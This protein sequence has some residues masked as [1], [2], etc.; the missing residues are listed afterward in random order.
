MVFA[1]Y[2]YRCLIKY[3]KL[4][5]SVSMNY[6]FIDYENVNHGGLD[7]IEKLS[8]NDEV[9]IIFNKNLNKTIP[10]EVFIKCTST[11]AKIKTITLDKIEKNYLD[12]RLTS[13]LSSKITERGN[14]DH[15]YII[16]KDKGYNAV[17]DHWQEKNIE[18]KSF[19]SINKKDILNKPKKKK[20]KKEINEAKKD[21]DTKITKED[22]NTIVEIFN[23][24]KS[25]N[26]FHTKL[27]KSLSSKGS[28]KI[29]EIYN[30]F[31]PDLK[32]KLSI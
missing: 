11:S 17:I 4:E 6:Y 30:Q 32:R 13:E 19:T 5:K 22:I 28:K 18:I 3:M 12:F 20:L 27:A 9:I 25:L 15:Y 14:K 2:K 7:G 16:S 26:E 10:L 29:A 23:T 24:S 1:L 8:Q 21:I 31:K